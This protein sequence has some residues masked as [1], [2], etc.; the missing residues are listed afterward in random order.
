MEHTKESPAQNNPPKIQFNCG[1]NASML[2]ESDECVLKIGGP[3]Y[4]IATNAPA[5]DTIVP[6]ALAWL[7]KC[8]Q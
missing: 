7:L 5:I 4:N 6:K 3:L 1:E 2:L 8:L